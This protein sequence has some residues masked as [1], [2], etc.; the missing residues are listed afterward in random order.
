MEEQTKQPEQKERKLKFGLAVGVDE[1]DQFVLEMLGDNPKTI[2][3]LG[4][5]Q[6]AQ[7]QVD[8]LVDKQLAQGSP[9]IANGINEV[10]N[11]LAE[12]E[13]NLAKKD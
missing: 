1:N 11:K 7:R 9:L 6:F 13:Q 10:L 2:E 5:V 4:C 8:L 12:L 3:L